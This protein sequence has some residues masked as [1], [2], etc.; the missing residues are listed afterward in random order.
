MPLRAWCAWLTALVRMAEAGYG[1]AHWERL[2]N[3]SI[4]SPECFVSAL[5]VQGG[6][7]CTHLRE[8]TVTISVALNG[9]PLLFRV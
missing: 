8:Q 1:R 4:K 5:R 2:S 7:L 3:H 6:T 9:W